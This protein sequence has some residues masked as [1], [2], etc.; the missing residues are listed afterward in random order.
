M[1][2]TFTL[3]LLLLATAA[4]AQTEKGNSFISGNISTGYSMIRFNDANSNRSGYSTIAAGVS[5]G[6]F[7]KDNIVWRTDM[8]ESFNFSFVRSEMG[9]QSTK[10]N[11]PTTALSLRTMGL[12]YFGKERWR[13]FVGGGINLSG[14]FTKARK[15]SNT[16]NSTD[17]IQKNNNFSVAP[18]F[19]AGAMYFLSKHLAIQL[20]ATTNSFPL[21][22]SGF[23]TGMYYWLKP[24]S[25]KVDPNEFSTLQKDRWMVG[26]TF[27]VN[28][29][30]A[31]YNTQYISQTDMNSSDANINVQAGKFVRD[32]LI[33]GASLSYSASQTEVP[34]NTNNT[35]Q[36]TKNTTNN[37]NGSVFLTK[38]LMTTRLTPYVGIRVNYGRTVNTYKSAVLDSQTGYMNSYS[39]MPD[40]GLA[41]LISNHFFV[42]SQLANFY[43]FY[44]VPANSTEKSFGANLSGGLR[45]NLRLSY[46]F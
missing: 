5:Y 17:E 27:G 33:V 1:K 45:P 46:V 25:F 28:A 14:G 22:I 24:T 35:I 3:G 11:I 39:L 42:E 2:H 31:R 43:M 16:P 26:A 9:F 23:S 41:Y 29:N 21:G 4:F 6:K 13:G 37:Y 12:Y 30:K 7:I 19:E 34:A 10:V 20:S 18:S 32:R 44:S 38:Y 8:S 15:V 40:I 36:Y